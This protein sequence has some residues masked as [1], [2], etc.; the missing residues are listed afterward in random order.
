MEP[1]R[2][3]IQWDI[4]GYW[5]QSQEEDEGPWF[6]VCY[7]LD[8]LAMKYFNTILC[9]AIPPH[10]RPKATAPAGLRLEPLKL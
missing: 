8:I 4:L 1:L 3:K 10:H 6:P 7:S 2:G 9:C 5:R